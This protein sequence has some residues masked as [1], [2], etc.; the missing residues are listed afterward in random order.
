M[1]PSSA[2]LR[3]AGLPTVRAPS[4]QVE[5]CPV[6][7]RVIS[8]PLSVRL[9]HGIRFLHHPLPAAP[10]VRFTTFLPIGEGYGLTM[11][12][13]CN[14]DAVGPCSPPGVLGAHAWRFAS[15]TTHSGAIWLQPV[16][17]VGWFGLT[18]FSARSHL[19]T[20]ASTLA[21]LRLLLPDTPV[22]HGSGA[23]QMTVGYF[24]RRLPTGRYLAA[25][26]R[27]VRL[28]GQPVLSQHRCLQHNSIGDFMSH[29]E[30]SVLGAE[31]LCRPPAIVM[32][33]ATQDVSP[34]DRPCPWRRC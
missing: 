7:R 14:R 11:F 16:S 6:S 5:V 28:M 21:P 22:P 20:I 4:D 17:N 12:R 33:H 26:L 29:C 24:V 13:R 2:L 34:L 31:R 3:E 25:V 8:Q 9:Q 10:S 1:P 19:L 27:R 30:K 32:H 18:T 23:S 15:S